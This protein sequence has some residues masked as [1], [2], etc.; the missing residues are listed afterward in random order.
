MDNI[1][2]DLRSL[3]EGNDDGHDWRIRT[4]K[5]SLDF[6]V[7][8]NVVMTIKADGTAWGADFIATGYPKKKK[9]G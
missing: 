7:N 3:N 4:N 5:D 8:G 9:Q 6:V 1:V 2:E